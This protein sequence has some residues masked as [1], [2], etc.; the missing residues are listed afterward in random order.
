M[1]NY[2]VVGSQNVTSHKIDSFNCIC[3]TFQGSNSFATP[4]FSHCLIR[5]G[6]SALDAWKVVEFA[7]TCPSAYSTL[8]V[9]VYLEHFVVLLVS[10]Q[11][12]CAYA[13]WTVLFVW[14]RCWS[15]RVKKYNVT[16]HFLI[17]DWFF[18]RKNQ[19]EANVKQ[20]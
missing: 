3:S 2:F 12:D 15:I 8:R 20:A 7:T 6:D 16:N 13:N 5:S 1:L 11:T 17:N 10:L 19:I 9:H 14:R 4:M 18:I